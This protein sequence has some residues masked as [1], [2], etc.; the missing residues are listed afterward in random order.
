MLKRCILLEIIVA[1]AISISLVGTR[2]FADENTG[3]LR[4]RLEE[5]DSPFLTA[6]AAHVVGPTAF[7]KPTDTKHLQN[8]PLEPYLKPISGTHRPDQDA[9]LLFASEYQLDTYVLFVESLRKTGYAGDVVMAIHPNDWKKHPIQEYLKSYAEPAQGEP[10]L[11]IFATKPDCFNM[12][13]HHVDSS[14]GG[15]RTC[16]FHEL[17]GTKD[18]VSGVITPVPDPRPDRT[19]ANIRYEIYWLMAINY[20]P[21]SWLMLV[22]ARDTVFQDNPFG[23]VPRSDPTDK[24]GLLYFFGENRDA[25]RI[26]LS[27]QNNKWIRTAYGDVIGDALADKPTIC[28]GATLGEQV[29]LET[30]LRAMVVEADE[31]G[32]VLMGSD[33]GFHNRLYYSSKLTNTPTI[34]SIT[35]FDQG[36]GIVNNMGALR[37]KPLAEWGNGNIVKQDGVDFQV[38]NWDGSVSPV[39]HQFDRH[40]ELSQYFF[41]TKKKDYL[42]A[43]R[44]RQK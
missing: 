2:V 34:K 5:E 36:K 42:E 21:H 25:T 26:G 6:P 35:V 16:Q 9:I 4:R 31:T 14:K 18:A 38:L 30:Y 11:V 41:K 28:S 27:K 32:T 19:V 23:N 3:L 37:T 43:W 29:A 7:P 44:S 13:R 10:H 20:N 40:K 39:V 17:Y 15:S 24:G 8:V 33:Q 1:L 22:D 12:E